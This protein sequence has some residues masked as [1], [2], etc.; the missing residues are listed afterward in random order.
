MFSKSKVPQSL[1]DAVSKITEQQIEE[2]LAD[3]FMKSMKKSGI[4]AK[5][6]DVDQKKKETQYKLASNGKSGNLSTGAETG[7]YPLGG[8]D[9][10]SGK[11]YSEEVE[12][13]ELEKKASKYDFTKTKSGK[14]VPE[15]KK[16]F[17]LSDKVA[18]MKKEETELVDEANAPSVKVPVKGGMR[19]YGG[20]AGGSAKAYKQQ[21]AD[22]FSSVRGPSSKELDDVESEKKKVK[23][24]DTSYKNRLLAMVA[25]N[26]AFEQELNE[27]LSK[28]ASAADW[29][30]DFVHSDNPKF[31]GKTTKQR[32]KMAL[33]AYY[34]KQR[35]EEF[36]EEESEQIDELSTNKLLTY[37]SAATEKLGKGTPEQDEKRKAGIGKSGSKII[38]NLG[39]RKEGKDPA[40][41]S[42]AGSEPPF[43]PP[44]NTSSSPATKDKSGAVHTPMSRAKHLARTAMKKISKDLSNK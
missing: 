31:K 19:V 26:Q 17:H 24:E 6:R 16:Q 35:N 28:D 9:E 18:N 8:R 33:G 20:A 14:T 44:Y 21:H 36:V 3:D 7:K 11:S 15:Q 40:M 39:L 27:V 43:A 4:N 12:K 38:K 25:E 42:G 10:K 2:G 34:A 5:I 32:Q 23:K 41:D 1:I 29:I 13:S 37:R 30:H 22:P